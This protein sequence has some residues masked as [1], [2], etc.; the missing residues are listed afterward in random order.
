MLDYGW[1]R[2]FSGLLAVTLVVRM[3][4]PVRVAAEETDATE[5]TEIMEVLETEPAITEPVIT[6]PVETTAATEAVTEPA[7][8]TVATEETVPETTAETVAETTE[9]NAENV[10]PTQVKLTVKVKS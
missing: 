3:L 2:L 9:A 5:T 6:E 4:P 8:T 1:K 10:K 7:E